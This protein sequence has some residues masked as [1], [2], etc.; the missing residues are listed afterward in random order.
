MQARATLILMVL[1][2]SA[3]A[4]TVMPPPTL[5][6]LSTVFVGGNPAATLEY[7]RLEIRPNGTGLITAQYLP[8]QRVVAYKI[9]KTIIKGYKVAFELVPIDRDAEPIYV[10]GDAVCSRLD[11]T[12]GGAP[13]LEWK[14]SIVLEPLAT[15]MARINAV[16]ERAAEVHQDR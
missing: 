6:C 11:L 16:N 13:K 5:R 2:T 4:R 8:E 14:R 1:A 12:V 15:V 9:T 7:F 10:R 3:A